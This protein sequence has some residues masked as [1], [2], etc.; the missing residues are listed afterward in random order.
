MQRCWKSTGYF[1]LGPKVVCGGRCG[2]P[3]Q[4]RCDR[5]SDWQP[6]PNETAVTFLE[7]QKELGKTLESLIA[8]PRDGSKS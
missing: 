7:A 3:S 1:S 2:W 5:C 4:T 6:L 8:A